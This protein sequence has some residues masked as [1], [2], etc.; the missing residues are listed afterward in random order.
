[1]LA[2][3]VRFRPEAVRDLEGIFGFI[4]ELTNDPAMASGYVRR[5]RNRCLQIGNVPRG[6]TPRDDLEP[7][8]RTVPFERRAVIAYRLNESGVE[9]TNIFYGGRDFEA[10]YRNR[11]SEH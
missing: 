6:G 9:I 10:L 3:E 8:L 4:V 7:G 2:V 1:M 5:I 11:P